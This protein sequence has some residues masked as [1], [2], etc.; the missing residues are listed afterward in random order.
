M[1]SKTVTFK[2]SDG[3]KVHLIAEKV[4]ATILYLRNQKGINMYY[5]HYG[6][7]RMFVTEDNI[8]VVAPATSTK[9]SGK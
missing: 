6:N 4:D 7:T 3:D 5:V 2:H 9:K 8:K 1:A